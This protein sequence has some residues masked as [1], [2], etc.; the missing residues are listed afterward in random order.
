MQLSVN[1][2]YTYVGYIFVTE[3]FI[4]G[5]KC[6]IIRQW[7]FYKLWKLI[8]T[9]GI[10]NRHVCSNLYNINI[11]YIPSRCHF[12][13]LY[14]TGHISRDIPIAF[15]PPQ[16]THPRYKTLNCNAVIRI[17]NT[18]IVDNQSVF[19]YFK[20]THSNHMI[21]HEDRATRC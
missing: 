16:I 1:G 10:L 4:W 8:L 2:C 3:N 12:I 6:I 17:V 11:I 19:I 9:P 14:Y 15:T 7:N 21:S 20:W 18:Q 5:E 13:K